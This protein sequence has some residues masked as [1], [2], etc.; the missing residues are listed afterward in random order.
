GD[1]LCDGTDQAWGADLTC[2]DCDGGDCMGGC[3]CEDDTS[4][5]DCCG[6]PDGDNSSCGSSG[7]VNGNGV[8]ITD[9]IEMVADIL[10]TSS[11][12]ECAA[13]EA[14][15]NGDGSVDIM[16]VIGA[17]DIILSGI[18]AGCTDAL[19]PEYNADATDDDGS[20][21]ASC[22]GNTTWLGDGFC[23]GSNNNAECAFDLGDCCP[24]SCA[25]AVENGCP[26]NP[27]GCWGSTPGS[28]CG[29]CA[30]CVDPSNPNSNGQGDCDVPPTCATTD[31]GG[32]VST[33]SCEALEGF[34]FDCS[35]CEA[36]GACPEDSEGCW[37]DWSNYGAESC[38]A[39][40][41]AFG[42]DCATL[43]A[44]YSWDCTG[45]GCP[46]DQAPACGDGE[47]NG[48]EDYTTCAADCEGPCEGL[49]V[50]M[51]DAFGDGW[52]GNVL[53]IGDESFTIESG[54]SA[55]GCYSGP[56]D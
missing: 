19:A 28:S 25:D 36:E 11:L 31:C 42:I 33:N 37:F 43:E 30:T 35:V 54:A 23:D 27:D 20:C 46:G 51:S 52:N 24:D 40:W 41:D 22:L 21:W 9:V 5:A 55:E 38:D 6:V 44:N 10:A 7:D 3:G 29:S 18:V 45:C 39:A 8:D 14:D 56:S 50:S 2:Y 15:I 4:C 1:G 12:E 47:C 16:D 48:D 32:W 53:T 17:V 26:D 13:N 34:G 49:T